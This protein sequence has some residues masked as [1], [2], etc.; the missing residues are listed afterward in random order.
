MCC[1][2]AKDL[3]GDIYLADL[4]NCGV[5]H[6]L[7]NDRDQGT[8][9]KC[10]VMV[11]PD[12][13]RSM[14]TFLGIS[15]KLSHHELNYECILDS[16]Y[17]YVEGYLA[18][19]ASGKN[20]AIHLRKYAEEND[21]RTALSF[22]DPGIV[23]SFSKEIAEIIGEKV[24]LIFCN[25]DEALSWGNT[26]NLNQAINRLKEVA[27]T[28]VITL[29]DAGAITFDGQKQDRI[30]AEHVRAIDTNGAG[31]MFA[32]AFLFA[33]ARG[34]SY[35]TAGRFANFAASRLVEYFG[36]RLP[37]KEYKKIKQ[38]FFGE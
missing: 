4:E 1:K 31:D 22:S 27:R 24:D 16:K 17:V 29:G 34:E 10:L 12:A 19:S 32:G 21:V 2:V 8:T 14:S 18:T 6:N 13:D 26:N 35:E 7:K 15:E 23:S 5:D 20:A 3:D 33:A 30:D 38:T 9:G 11:T 36:P 28:F 25:E 37:V